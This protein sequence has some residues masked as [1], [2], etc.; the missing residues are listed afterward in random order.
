MRPIT[1]RGLLWGGL[2]LL[3]ALLPL[4]IAL[5]T[6]PEEPRGL[7]GATGVMFGLLALGV[8]GMQVVISGRHRW[9]AESIG[10][11]N[12]LQFHRQTGLVALW[13]V[14]AHP[15]LIFAS[16]P[17]YLEFLDPRDDTLRALALIGLLSA[18]VV[19]IV[20]SLWRVQ[21]GLSYE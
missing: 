21:L 16:D 20:S 17:S 6:V 11:D 10:F 12:I 8:F 7:L 1:R 14:L 4:G 15:L 18:S 2:Y 5:L 9:F 13:L 3:L 19:L